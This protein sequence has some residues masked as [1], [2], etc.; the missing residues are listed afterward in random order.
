MRDTTS[1]MDLR[2]IEALAKASKPAHDSTLSQDLGISPKEDQASIKTLRDN[3]FGMRDR[4]LCG[5]K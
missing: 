4:C 5:G 2:L 3:G 1:P